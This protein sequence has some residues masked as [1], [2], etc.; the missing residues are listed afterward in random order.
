MYVDSLL[1]PCEIKCDEGRCWYL[2]IRAMCL[3]VRLLVMNVS[4][5]EDTPATYLMLPQ[6]SFI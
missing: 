1:P 4:A 3:Y 2:D 5:E 6:M